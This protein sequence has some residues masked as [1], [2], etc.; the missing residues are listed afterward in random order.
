MNHYEK[1]A[2]VEKSPFEI[3]RYKD[4]KIQDKVRGI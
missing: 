4:T 3:Q 1:S 2:E